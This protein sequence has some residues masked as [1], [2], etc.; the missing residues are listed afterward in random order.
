MRRIIYFIGLIPLLFA[1]CASLDG[2]GKGGSVRSEFADLPAGALLYIS[3]DTTVAKELAGTLLAR[4]KLNAKTM[5]TFFNMTN[6]IAA[7]VYPE[8]TEEPENRRFL[9]IGYGKNYPSSLSAFSFFFDPAWKRTKSVTGGKYWRSSK[10]R[11]SL[12]IQKNKARI[13][14]AD[15]F[16]AEDAAETPESFTLFSEGAS[17]SAWLTRIE[18]INRA[19]AR[20]DLPVT[21]PATALFAAVFPH[22]KDWVIAF[23]METPSPAQARGLVSVLSMVR[24]ALAGNYIRGDTTILRLLLSEPPSIDDSAIILKSPPLPHET[25]AGL[26]DSLS[27]YLR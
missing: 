10:N 19:L 23:R 18:P 6:R 26:I 1:S 17:V 13:S 15:P 5:R 2:A 12:F 20:I 25:L 9:L 14:D 22:G 3:I 24:N 4:Y 27:I 11:L 16:F 8:R 21:I 7:A